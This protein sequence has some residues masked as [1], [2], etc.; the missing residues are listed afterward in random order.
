[1]LTTEDREKLLKESDRL[2]KAIFNA[3]EDAR[4]LEEYLSSP[5]RNPKDLDVDTRILQAIRNENKTLLEKLEEMKNISFSKSKTFEDKYIKD[6]NRKTPQEHL[7]H[8]AELHGKYNATRLKIDELKRKAIIEKSDHEFRDYPKLWEF[9]QILVDRHFENIDDYRVIYNNKG[10]SVALQQPFPNRQ[11]KEGE[12]SSHFDF[13]STWFDFLDQH[14]LNEEKVK[15]HGLSLIDKKSSSNNFKEDLSLL[16]RLMNNSKQSRSNLEKRLNYDTYR[17]KEIEKTSQ[18]PKA[19]KKAKKTKKVAKTSNFDNLVETLIDNNGS[20]DRTAE[21]MVNKDHHDYQLI[22]LA[23]TLNDKQIQ[24]LSKRKTSGS[25]NIV[26]RKKKKGITFKSKDNQTLKS[27]GP[28]KKKKADVIKNS[29]LQKKRS[30]TPAKMSR[31]THFNAKSFSKQSKSPTSGSKVKLG[32]RLGARSPNFGKKEKTRKSGLS[33]KHKKVIKSTSKSR[34]NSKK[35][36]ES[37]ISSLQAQG[38]G[39]IIGDLF[40]SLLSQ[41]LPEPDY[42]S[43]LTNLLTN[44]KSTQMEEDYIFEEMMLIEEIDDHVFAERH[45]EYGSKVVELP[46]KN[47]PIPEEQDSVNHQTR[48]AKPLEMIIIDDQEFTNPEIQVTLVLA[49]EYSDSGPEP[50][51]NQEETRTSEIRESEHI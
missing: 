33:I 20:L 16:E 37:S 44:T 43:Q 39:A 24:T 31:K 18:K 34:S 50:K 28:Q 51:A 32:S 2:E 47:Q 10:Q 9:S 41:K 3:K 7:K 19:E 30:V 4:I 35:I 45:Q 1:M 48:L 12:L 26:R 36:K 5:H 15:Q 14:N 46:I 42:G 25:K 6:P 11:R 29:I 40:A 23:N 22:D 38:Q 8:V 49:S 27:L 17:M 21:K 13:R